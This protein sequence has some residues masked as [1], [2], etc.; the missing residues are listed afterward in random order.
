MRR[1]SAALAA[2][3]IRVRDFDLNKSDALL[4]RFFF[5]TFLHVVQITICPGRTGKNSPHQRASKKKYQPDGMG[6]TPRSETASRQS[7]WEVRNGNE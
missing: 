1:S 4:F 6:L 7:F 3:L 5:C 2:P